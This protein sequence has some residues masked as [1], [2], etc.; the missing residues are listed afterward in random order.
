MYGL[1]ALGLL[2]GILFFFGF[3][4]MDRDEKARAADMKVSK[5]TKTPDVPPT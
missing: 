3:Y 2:A 5:V 4:Y 1:Y